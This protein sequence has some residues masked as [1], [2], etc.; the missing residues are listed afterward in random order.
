MNNARFEQ[1]GYIEGELC[2]LSI[3]LDRNDVVDSQTDQHVHDDYGHHE[4][5]D[6]E[7]KAGVD[8]EG[9][10]PRLQSVLCLANFPVVVL[11]EDSLKLVFPDHHH[12]GLEQCLRRVI[13]CKLKGEIKK[14]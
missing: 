12:K 1:E 5:E 3:V 13:K 8:R 2:K 4:D 14:S 9:V 10:V 7:D 6:D 11:R